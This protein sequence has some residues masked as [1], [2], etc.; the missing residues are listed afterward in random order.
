MEPLSDRIELLTTVLDV[1]VVC[2]LG[3]AVSSELNVC[4]TL[5]GGSVEELELCRPPFAESG[6]CVLL[7]LVADV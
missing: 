4:D 7:L 2:E 3:P 1:P 6:L 5:L